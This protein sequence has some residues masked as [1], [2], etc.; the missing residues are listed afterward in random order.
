MRIVAIS[1]SLRTGSSNTA[2][3]RAAAS[4]MPD[5]SEM[6]LF[7]GLGELPAFNPDVDVEGT[8]DAVNRF[9]TV[10]GEA[11]GVAISSPEYARGV[12]GALKNALDWLVGSGE[13]YEKP[14]ALLHVSARGEVAQNA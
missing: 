3:L 2:L 1:G 10:I 12:V 4:Q 7:E 9:R 8:P 13:L 11:D 14:V 5:G 6:L